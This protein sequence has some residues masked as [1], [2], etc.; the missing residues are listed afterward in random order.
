M[1]VQRPGK[2]PDMKFA[3][4]ALLAGLSGAIL[5]AYLQGPAITAP[6]GVLGGVPVAED[7]TGSIEPALDAVPAA[8][9]RLIDLRNGS[10]CR[11]AAPAASDTAFRR[12]PVGPDCASSPDLA[13][14]ALWRQ[15][16]DGAL[17]MAD[18][19]GHTVLEFQPGDGVLF[20]SVYPADALI[21]IVPARG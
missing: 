19:R 3:A 4:I 13:R 15:T 14:V 5:A 1:P 18:A 20:E 12:M 11:I 10:T 2:I 6:A 7:I 16:S 21:T 17:V 9:I 8:A